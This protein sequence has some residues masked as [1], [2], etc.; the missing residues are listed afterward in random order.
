MSC[1]RTSTFG[2][3]WHY[4]KLLCTFSQHRDLPLHNAES[5]ADIRMFVA[6]KSLESDGGFRRFT[7][8]AYRVDRRDWSTT[9]VSGGRAGHIPDML[10]HERYSRIISNFGKSGRSTWSVSRPNIG[11]SLSTVQKPSAYK[12][13]EQQ[14]Q[15]CLNCHC[16]RFARKLRHLYQPHPRQ[17]R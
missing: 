12:Q 13:Q 15:A 2:C 7:C 16:L 4:D 9:L 6:C 8:T 17:Q 5:R 1:N 11:I 10:L 3:T 14:W